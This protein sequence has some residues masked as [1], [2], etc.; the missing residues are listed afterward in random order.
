LADAK[1]AII[2]RFALALEQ[3]TGVLAFA[4][5]QKTY[6]FAPDYWDNCPGQIMAVTAEGLQRVAR[7]YLNPDTMQLVAVGDADKIKPAL[8]KYGPLEVYDSSGKLAPV[9]KTD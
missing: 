8:E 3:P 4:M 9:S 7:T 6:G 5:V 2:A 1:R